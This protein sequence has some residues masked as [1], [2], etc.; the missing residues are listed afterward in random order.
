MI[1]DKRDILLI[2]FLLFVSPGLQAFSDGRDK[3]EKLGRK[4]EKTTSF[5]QLQEDLILFE[6]FEE[7]GVFPPVGWT[8]VNGEPGAY[9]Q[10]NNIY[11]YD[12]DLSA[13]AYQG[14]QSSYQANEWLITPQIDFDNPAARWLTFFGFTHSEPDGVREKL[15][16]MAVDQVYDNVETL[17]DNAIILDVVSLGYPWAE[18]IIDMSQLSGEMHLAFVY[19]VREE[20]ETSFAWLYLDKVK[21]GNFDIHTLTMEAPEG[22]GSTNPAP[23]QHPY[24]DG[25]TVVLQAIPD[26]GWDFSHWEG[27]VH[28]PYNMNTM[29]LM[30]EDKT[31][32]A[33]FTPLEPYPVPFFEDFSGLTISAIPVGWTKTHPNWGAWPTT[34]AGGARPEM[35]F[36]WNPSSDDNLFRLTTRPINAGQAS[37]LM[38]EFRH[39]VNDFLGNY[40]LK[41]QSSTD[42]I[43]WNDEWAHYMKSSAREGEKPAKRQLGRDHGPEV[44]TVNLNHLTGEEAFYI[45]FVFEGDNSRINSW[46]IDDVF[47]GDTQPYYT[48][49]F[50]V[51]N[52]LDG[53]PIGGVLIGIE[54][55][56]LYTHTNNNGFASF[57]LTSGSYKALLSK[58]EFNNKEI[59]FVVE[60]E[61]LLI[62]VEMEPV[63]YSHNVIFNVNMGDAVFGDGN[64]A[65][66]PDAN[67]Q[68]YVAG[69]FVGDWITPGENPDYRL[70]P[71][72]ENPDM[73][74][75]TLQLNKDTYEYKYFVVLDEQ[76]GWDYGEWEGEPNRTVVVLGPDVVSDVW[77]DQPVDTDDPD[78]F[79]NQITVFPNPAHHHVHLKV[80]NPDGLSYVLFDMN[81]GKLN[82]EKLSAYKTSIPVY[83]LST[84]TYLI[85][86]MKGQK[87]IKNVL[88][89]K[90]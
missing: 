88:I 19:L 14:Y 29:I 39:F 72:P 86:I 42:T 59:P 11:S 25:R 33:H 35:R 1:L 57:E 83:N 10:Q 68:V 84:G 62:E 23:G 89:I 40:I 38:L 65:F 2:L 54:N 4:N 12:G 21:V 28:E 49:N 75:V 80:D 3:S 32:K 46:F 44:V 87:D 76:P 45:A 34:N 41:V 27:D 67:H 26:Y 66:D 22:D 20:D 58:E 77:G 50:L 37:E 63:D 16:I 15:H 43:H 70:N 69:S 7:E 51:K 81:G 64:I 60:E 56:G 78:F 9:W 85:K 82:A 30:D 73:Y 36:H 52:K 74:T 90:K 53:E 8:Y 47:I 48:V 17:Y 55:T 61:N 13:R 5:S 18:Y 79:H 6:S 31:V 24:V 71:R